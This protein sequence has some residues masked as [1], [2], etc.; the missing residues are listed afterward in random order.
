MRR[1]TL[2]VWILPV[3]LIAAGCGGEETTEPETNG[4][5]DKGPEMPAVELPDVEPDVSTADLVAVMDVIE[6]ERDKPLVVH[7]WADW[8]P[9]CHAELPHV[10]TM[11]QKL[12]DRADF[13]AVS[14]DFTDNQKGHPAI[15]SAVEVVTAAAKKGKLGCPIYVVEGPDAG[16][17]FYSYFAVDA[18]VP[19]TIVYG[20]DGTK[21]GHHGEFAGADEAV[22]WYEKVTKK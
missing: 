21:L 12:A 20:A 5:P 10:A 2:L 16:A 3:L 18:F 9:E 19:Q 17:G 6:A 4:E 14:F 8:C 13:V 22:A 15:A 11:R 7:L 1:G